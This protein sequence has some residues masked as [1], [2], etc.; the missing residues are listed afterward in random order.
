M[1]PIE[2]ILSPVQH[3]EGI[4][5][6]RVFAMAGGTEPEPVWELVGYSHDTNDHWDLGQ[7]KVIATQVSSQAI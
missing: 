6:L 7:V 2:H 1:V 5:A 3:N 4:R